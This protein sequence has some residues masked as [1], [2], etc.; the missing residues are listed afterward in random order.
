MYRNSEGYA[1]PTAGAALAHIVYEER[2]A[3][4]QAK[5]K[6]MEEQRAKQ[7]ARRKQEAQQR[8]KELEKNTHWV[9]AWT[10]D[11][12]HTGQ[13]K[14]ESSYTY[15]SSR[16]RELERTESLAGAGHRDHPAGS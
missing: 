7:A 10:R 16:A 11:G 8:R 2:M 14:G 4:R 12:T 3:R 13:R 1:D 15:H 6:Q 9:Q 5:A